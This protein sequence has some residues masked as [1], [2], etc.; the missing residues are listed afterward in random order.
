M[1]RLILF[2]HGKAETTPLT[3][4]DRER[5]LNERGRIDSVKTAEWL[6]LAGYVPD[7]VLLSPSARTI[8]TWDCALPSFPDSLTEMRDGLYLGGIDEILAEVEATPAKFDTVMLIGHNPGLQEVA[9]QLATE[10]A[11]DDEQIERMN[12]GFPT[13]TACVIGLEDNKPVSLEAIYEPPRK[14]EA[15]PRW[16]FVRNKTGETP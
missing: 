7:L 13:S 15:A 5:R 9:V 4:G 3:G 8:A 1:R 10:A 11:A 6:A 2:R 14:G 16:L 12:D